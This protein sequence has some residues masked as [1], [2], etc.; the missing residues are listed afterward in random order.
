MQSLKGKFLISSST[1]KED[2]F[3]QSVVFLIEHNE[4]GAFGLVVNR[5]LDSSLYDVLPKMSTKAKNIPIYEGGPV[6]PEVLFVLFYSDSADVEGEQV[7][8]NI[9]L[10]TSLALL[11]D[12]IETEKPFHVYH[13]Y[14][15]WSATQLEE[16]LEAKTWVVAEGTKNIIFH[17]NPVVVWR[18]ALLHNGG[19]YSY[20]AK[21]VKDPFLN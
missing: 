17:E 8:E 20:F 3:V 5:P 12:L 19:I 6:R 10:G 2:N 1:L 13:G 4:E 9:Y 15:G 18:E 14:A 7:I 21:N 11:E 16:E